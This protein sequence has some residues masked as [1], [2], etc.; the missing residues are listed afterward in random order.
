MAVVRIETD[1]PGA[2]IYVDRADLGARGT[3]PRVLAFAPG[4]VRILVERAGH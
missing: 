1:P 3:T 2:T 4:T